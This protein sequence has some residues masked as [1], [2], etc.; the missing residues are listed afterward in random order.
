MLE[1]KISDFQP[2]PA[3]VGIGN[4]GMYFT[5]GSDIILN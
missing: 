2:C 1:V 3:I 4:Q 5:K